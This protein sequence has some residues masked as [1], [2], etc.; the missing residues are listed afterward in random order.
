[1]KFSIVADFVN[2]T[3][4]CI[5]L[6]R[7]YINF[8]HV[9]EVAQPFKG[10]VAIPFA[11]G[12]GVYAFEGAGMIL[13]LEGN[14]KNRSQFGGVLGLAFSL[15]TAFYSLFGIAGYFGFGEQTKDI[16]TLNLPAHWTTDAVKLGICF[17]LLFTFPV[18]MTPLHEIY[19]RRMYEWPLFQEYVVPNKNLRH[20]IQRTI[21][22]LV[23]LLVVIIAVG[24]PKFSVF[25]S[26]V[27]SS[28]CS[29]LG[30]VLPA[31]FHLYVFKEDLTIKE[32]LADWL[33]IVFGISFG[34]WGTIQTI[35]DM[36]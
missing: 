30:F 23:V 9:E 31:L 2:L 7:D 27:G 17:S 13:S 15:I 11:F 32:K 24:V 14:M 22:S 36:F 29:L 16:I 1:M 8:P 18:M 12:V 19:E 5:V 33:L 3:A 4:Y 21:R 35:Q 25:I 34:A 28:A 26:L 6:S 10:L 20:G